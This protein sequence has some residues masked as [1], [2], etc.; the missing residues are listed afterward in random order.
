MEPTGIEP[1]T[2]CLQN[3]RSHAVLSVEKSRFAGTEATKL[4]ARMA[5]DIRALP[6]IFVVSG[7]FGGECLAGCGSPGCWRSG[8]R[9]A[10]HSTETCLGDL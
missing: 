3:A 4:G 8:E 9:K 10:Q 5:A 1:V 7:T 2:S 6:A